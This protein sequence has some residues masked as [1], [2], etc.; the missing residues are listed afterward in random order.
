MNESTYIL[1][2]GLLNNGDR[3]TI[4]SVGYDRSIQQLVPK[5]TDGHVASANI[6]LQLTVAGVAVGNSFF[7]PSGTNA[8]LPIDLSA[9]PI[10]DPAGSDLGLVI[11]TANG[12]RDVIVTISSTAS[13]S[14]LDP[15]WHVPTAGDLQSR[16]D[17]NTYAEVTSA[18]MQGAQADPLPQ[19]LADLTQTIRSLASRHSQ[20]GPA[21]TIPASFKTYFLSLC[22][23]ELSGRISAVRYLLESIKGEVD[24]ANK[25]LDMLAKGQWPI[26][27]PV[28]PLPTQPIPGASW[29]SD[30][31]IDL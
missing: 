18:V 26:E 6:V 1:A 23:A 16:I 25:R 4:G 30:T 10:T 24:S 13:G 14:G 11:V 19:I 27:P 9:H 22:K 2:P 7:I 3:T 21:G 29:G 5:T 31:A 20:L 8:A 17:A 28:N 15:N 12:E